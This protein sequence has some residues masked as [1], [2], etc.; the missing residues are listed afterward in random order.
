MAEAGRIVHLVDDDESIR[1]SVSF[2]L[3]TSGYV[4]KTYASGVEFLKDVRDAAPGVILLD[5]QMPQV[6]GWEMLRQVQERHGAGVIPVVMFSGRTDEGADQ[7]TE[8]GAQG[9]VGKPFDAEQL[10]ASTKA[11]LPV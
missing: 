3:R 8:R 9:F 6:D 5:V 4:V 1:R 7:A 11:L 2:M 10:V